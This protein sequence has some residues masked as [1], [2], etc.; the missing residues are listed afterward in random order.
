MGSSKLAFTSG[1]IAT[2]ASPIAPERES[3][4]IVNDGTAIGIA[5]PLLPFNRGL[6]KG[7]RRQ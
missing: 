3:G 7:Q 2:P 1:D 6:C 4:D 5:F